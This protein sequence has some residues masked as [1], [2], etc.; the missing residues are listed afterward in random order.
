MRSQDA[1]LDSFCSTD[2]KLQHKT[3]QSQSL[4]S[5]I[6][7]NFTSPVSHWPR[8]LF[9]ITNL[10]QLSH[11]ARHS[12]QIGVFESESQSRLAISILRFDKCNFYSQ[13]NKKRGIKSRLDATR[14][15]DV[16]NVKKNAFKSECAVELGLWGKLGAPSKCRQSLAR[17]AF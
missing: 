4:V 17:R 1:F 12:I 3:Y 7:L 10:L 6:Q 16:L 8:N 2:L 9:D 15:L 11:R 14:R 13:D 5:L